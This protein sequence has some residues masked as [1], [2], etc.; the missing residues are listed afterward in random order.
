MTD[1]PDSLPE[2]PGSCWRSNPTPS[3]PPQPLF[4]SA[5][6]ARKQKF[7]C[8]VRAVWIDQATQTAANERH[9]VFELIVKRF[10]GVEGKSISG[11]TRKDWIRGR[12]P[13]NAVLDRK[14]RWFNGS[15]S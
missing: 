12:V 5:G 11:A 1:A 13:Q 3:R 6:K 4:P 2:A 8:D 7:R 9:A 10:G 14:V 15:F